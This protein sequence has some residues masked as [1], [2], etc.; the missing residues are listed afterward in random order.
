MAQ[1]KLAW[2]FAITTIAL[3][4]TA[5]DNLVVATAI[6]GHPA[7][8]ARDAVRAR[9]D[10]ERVHAD[11]RG[12]A[13]HGCSARRPLRT[14]ANV[15]HRPGD[16]HRRVGARRALDRREH[17]DRRARAAGARRRDRHAAH[18]RR[19]SRGDV[20]PEKRGAILGAWGG[21]AGLAVAIGPV[22]GGAIVSG[23]AWQ[24]IFWLNVPI[25]VVAIPLAWRRLARR[26]ART[27]SSTSTGSSLAV[28]GLLGIVLGL[29]R[30]NAVG[31]GSGEV[32][33][34]L[35]VGVVLHRRLPLVGDAH[36]RPDAAAP[37]SSG[38]ARSRPRTAPRSRCTSACSARSSC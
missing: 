2:T 32:L 11:L 36:G 5:L 15:R 6:P 8:P 18:A 27:E 30:A 9:V 14:Q 35:V 17:A 16:L 26:A 37:R 21:I 34:A 20:P 19:S 33:A 29:V 31:W 22:I 12:A 25:G 10:G 24:W 23:I 4:M 38:S 1:N 7:G 3:F 13:P 28:V